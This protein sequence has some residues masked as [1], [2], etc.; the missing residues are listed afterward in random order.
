MAASPLQVRAVPFFVFVGL[1]LFQG[2]LGAASAYWVYALKTLVGA[3]FIWWMKPLVA[4]MRWKVSVEAI[5]TGVLVFVLWVGLDSYYPKIGAGGLVWNPHQHFDATWAWVFVL[6]RVLGST[7]VVPCLEEVFYRSFAYRYLVKPDFLTV[8]LGMFYWMPF[9]VTSVA[10]GVVHS[11]WL[12]G[13]LC[14][15]IYQGLVCWRKRLGDAMVAHAVTNFLLGLW[16]IWKGAW[17][18]W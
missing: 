12:P 17:Q 2:K 1:T 6:V 10:F 11:Q 14:G 16:I 7:L 8:P 18:F 4:E 13:I 5:V 9:V 3:W 15:L